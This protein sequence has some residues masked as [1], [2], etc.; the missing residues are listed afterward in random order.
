MTAPSPRIDCAFPGGNIV[1][2]SISG[3]TVTLRQD[4][5]TT[6]EWWFYWHF[7]VRGCAGRTL[8]FVFT[9]GDVFTA[10]GPCFSADGRRWEW[11]GREVVADNAFSFAFPPSADEAYFSSGIPYT[12]ANLAGFLAVR[13]GLPVVRDVLAI[14]EHGRP[15][16]LLRLG[17]EDA[18]DRRKIIVT[19][20]HH[21]C[22]AVANFVM[23][24]A[25]EFWG[26][27]C[28]EAAVLRERVAFTLIPFMDKDGVEEGDQGKCR[29]P[30]DHNR[31]YTDSP[32]YASTRALMAQAELW[33][34][35][36][37]LVLDLHCPWIRGGR[38]EEIFFVE[39][40]P[41]AGPQTRRFSQVLADTQL[42]A[43]VYNPAHYLASGVEWNTDSE[44]CSGYFARRSSARLSTSVEFPYALAGGQTVSAGNAR[45]FGRD[46]ARAIAV[47][48][49]G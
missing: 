41:E 43:L 46:L 18:A 27:P 25:M 7:R 11:L 21:A 8:R 14:S 40:T 9:D 22:E 2:E 10:R 24:G 44:S 19:A 15:V 48:V 1:V 42:G 36:L 29:A 3:D 47:Y 23:E 35:K 31:D 34:G 33:P 6:T 17:C 37:D 32:F 45:E 4:L 12:E 20:R 28:D 13:A 16:E 39:A 49:G 5:R 30:H 26:D 38:N